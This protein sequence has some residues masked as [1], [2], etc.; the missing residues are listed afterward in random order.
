MEWCSKELV[1]VQIT[2]KLNI[3]SVR[4]VGYTDVFWKKLC[5]NNATIA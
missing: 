5:C 3:L 2:N 1:W 4:V